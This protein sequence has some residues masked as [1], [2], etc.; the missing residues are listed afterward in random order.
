MK[1]HYV[2]FAFVPILASTAVFSC[3][4]RPPA[5]SE[6]DAGPCFVAIAAGRKHT[7]ALASGAVR[8]WGDDS[9]GELGVALPP[10]TTVSNVPAM[11]AAPFVDPV[12]TMAAAAGGEFTCALLTSGSVE[13]WGADDSNELG[14]TGTSAYQVSPTPVPLDQKATAIAVGSLDALASPA[15]GNS[16][17]GCALMANTTV[18]CWG[19]YRPPGSNA[20]STGPVTISGLSSVTAIAAGGLTACALVTDGTDGK[21][22]VE[23]FG[24]NTNGQLGND[25]LYSSMPQPV[26]SVLHGAT[27]VAV[28]NTFACAV[29]GGTVSCWGDNRHN[30]LG[31][32]ELDAPGGSVRTLTSTTPIPVVNLTDVIA[33][34]AGGDFACAEDAKG[35]I[36]CWGSNDSGQL[37]NGTI[38]GSSATPVMVKNLG[39]PST[40]ALGQAHGCAFGPLVASCWGDNTYGQLGDGQQEAAASSPVMVSNAHGGAAVSTVCSLPPPEGGVEAGT[41]ACAPPAPVAAGDD[42][43]CALVP[44]SGGRALTC[45][46]DDKLNELGTATTTVPAPGEGNLSL[47]GMPA[48]IVAPA[49]GQFACALTTIPTS[50]TSMQATVSTNVECWG[51][52]AAGELGFSPSI[53][54]ALPSVVSFQPGTTVRAIAA[55]STDG[56]AMQFGQ[57]NNYGLG[58]GFACAIVNPPGTSGIATDQVE[59]W[60]SIYL[61]TVKSYVGA[62]PTTVLNGGSP[63]AGVTA[64]AAGAVSAC[65]LKMD[66]TVWCWGDNQVGELGNGSGSPAYQTQAV[67]VAGLVGAT[68]VAV[69]DT[70]ACALANGSVWCWGDDAFG[71]LG[72]ALPMPTP[73]GNYSTTPVQ[74]HLGN[75]GDPGTPVLLTAGGSFAC[76]SLSNGAVWC[77]GDSRDGQLGLQASSPNFGPLQVPSLSAPR[78]LV[79]GHDHA[80]AVLGDGT[81]QCWGADT[82]GQ[83]GTRTTPKTLPVTQVLGAGGVSLADVCPIQP[84][85]PGPDGGIHRDAGPEADAPVDAVHPLDAPEEVVDAPEDTVLPFDGPKDVVTD[86]YVRPD[87][88]GLMCRSQADC[89]PASDVCCLI[90]TGPTVVSMCMPPLSG[91]TYCPSGEPQLC[92]SPTECPSG[93]SCDPVFPS[94][95]CAP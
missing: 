2:L 77:W 9:A 36:W 29:V 44:Q 37:G 20:V 34:V 65:A 35:N 15:A 28:G 89:T 49:G 43:T 41:P 54:S 3:T 95:T 50:G 5:N 17:F 14:S 70:F 18:E 39:F 79:A 92:A 11:P 51:A 12:V 45:W 6:T 72:V 42:F 10:G 69:G 8:C 4:S 84:G 21:S 23:C 25:L 7:C 55:G 64:I 60:G 80:C 63:L 83:L 87:G 27:A 22:D 48:E 93:D 82:S 66:G 58:M 19:Q 56:M 73:E 53:S 76:T 94:S 47:I 62:T 57:T 91:P 67:Q 40:L 85:G 78:A 71:Q 30:Q 13:C 61:E 88:P 74:A 46:G 16:G 31:N 68:S 38:G 52:N 33:L 1:R 86:L 75:P 90:S 81:L 26:S 59:C 24:Q 32:P